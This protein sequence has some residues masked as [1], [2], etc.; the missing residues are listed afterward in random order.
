M[1]AIPLLSAAIIIFK[2][3]YMNEINIKEHRFLSLIKSEGFVP[4]IIGGFLRYII[5]Q[6]KINNPYYTEEQRKPLELY[7]NDVLIKNGVDFEVWFNNNYYSN[8][9]YRYMGNDYFVMVTE[10]DL[11]TGKSVE[12]NEGVAK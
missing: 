6:W 5:A 8:I 11:S 10:I 4:I 12:L 7:I 9:Q 2:T 1:E 3:K